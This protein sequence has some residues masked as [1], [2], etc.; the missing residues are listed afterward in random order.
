MAVLY[1]LVPLPMG[2]AYFRARFEQEAYAES[3]RAAA[4]VWGAA[5]PRRPEYRAYIVAQFLG[6]SYGWMWPFRRALERWY[7]RVLATLDPTSV[8]SGPA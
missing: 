3:I 7:D 2:V 8:T 1:L 4:E 6:P 5:Y